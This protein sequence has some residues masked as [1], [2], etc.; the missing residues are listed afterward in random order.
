MIAMRYGRA[1]R[2]VVNFETRLGQNVISGR[3]VE[4]M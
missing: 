3:L 2:T 1:V 4:C